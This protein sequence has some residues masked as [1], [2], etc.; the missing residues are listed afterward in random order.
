VIA[1]DPN[2][3]LANRRVLEMAIADGRWTIDPIA[4]TDEEK[5]NLVRIGTTR[6]HV[7]RILGP[8]K[9]TL[10]RE[11][12]Y[13]RVPRIEL[14]QSPVAPRSISITYSSEDVV[15]DKKFYRDQTTKRAGRWSH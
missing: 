10:G 15:I 5:F 8:P 2:K 3:A 1:G 7:E 13:G 14:W 9:L 6:A 11:V 12:Y 4:T